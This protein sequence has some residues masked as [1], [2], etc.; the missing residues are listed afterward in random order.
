MAMFFTAGKPKTYTK[1]TQIYINSMGQTNSERFASLH[2]SVTNKDESSI[3][4]V[5]TNYN[6]NFEKHGFIMFSFSWHNGKS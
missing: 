4:V 2:P 6:I 5:Q 3:G 1:Q